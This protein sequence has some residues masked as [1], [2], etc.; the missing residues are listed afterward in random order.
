VVDFANFFRE[1]LPM[2]TD[3]A[4]FKINARSLLSN[5]ISDRRVTLFKPKSA[6]PKIKSANIE[7]HSCGGISTRLV[8]Q[9]FS[10]AD[11]SMCT[12]TDAMMIA[13]PIIAQPEGC[14]PMKI[15]T[16][17]GFSTGST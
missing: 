2:K 5:A 9:P 12:T 16:Q 13:P 1:V 7:T 17:M 8:R 4:S 6:S 15:N 10:L 3:G 11:I 14:S